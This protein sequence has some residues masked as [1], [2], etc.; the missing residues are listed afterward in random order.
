MGGHNCVLCIL[1]GFYVI[2]TIAVCRKKVPKRSHLPA[3][4][5]WS[6]S[7]NFKLEYRVSCKQL[8]RKSHKEE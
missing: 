2:V 1:L 3:P 6:S 4:T 5:L 8:A 7:F